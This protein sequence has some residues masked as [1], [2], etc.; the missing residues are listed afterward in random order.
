M[1]ICERFF[2]YAAV[3][4]QS[5]TQAAC[6]PSTAKQFDLSA[7]LAEDLKEIGCQGVEVDEHA[8]VY[9]YRPA[10]DGCGDLPSIGF[11][12][13]LD[14]SP[15]VTGA[16]VRPRLIRD[17]DG[18]DIVLNSEL[19]ITT[20]VEDFPALKKY[21]GKDLIVTDGTTLLGADDKGGIVAIMRALELLKGTRHGRVA[22]CFPPDEEIGHGASLLDL[23][24]FACDFAYTV[25]GGELGEL[26]F[27]TFNAAGAL[28]EVRGLNIHTGTAK[29]I[30]KNASL[31]A[32]EFDSLLPQAER[33]QYTSGY[34]GFFHLC[35]MSGDESSARLE[36]LIRD[37]DRDVFARRKSDMRAA[38]EFL[39]RKYSQGTVTLTITDTYYN[40]REVLSDR[41]Y[42]VDKAVDAM[43]KC[44]AEPYFIATRGGTDGS[45]LSF[46]GLPCPNIGI[47]GFNYH[48]I[49]ETVC[50]QSMETVARVLCAIAQAE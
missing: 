48:G 10:T 15:D 22:V 30:M 5:D 33:P 32:M 4:T 26:S 23:D 17:Y 8:Y 6:V 11:I 19:G 38:A 14:T 42:I 12:A 9:G 16:N 39:N 13:H 2:R 44:G 47:G 49:N 20:R 45:A 18:E 40:M 3:D 46:R 43:K 7:L 1:D 41:M 50:V 24:K 27:E 25:D 21:V 31:I 28:V 29:G 36:Y 34:E 37:H 35:E